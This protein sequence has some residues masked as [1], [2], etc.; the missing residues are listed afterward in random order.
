MEQDYI[1][2]NFMRRVLMFDLVYLL[3]LKQECFRSD[4]DELRFTITLILD[5]TRVIAE[6]EGIKASNDDL[7][8]QHAFSKIRGMIGVVVPSE[9]CIASFNLLLLDQ[10]KQKLG[11]LSC[12]D[13]MVGTPDMFR[14]VDKEIIIVAG[15]RNSQVDGLGAFEDP[16]A[17]QLLMTRARSFFWV[18][19]S[20]PQFSQHTQWREY[21]QSC[22]MLS[23]GR[24]TNY[25]SF[26]SH[27]DWMYPRLLHLIRTFVKRD[28]S[29]SPQGRH[30]ADDHR[31]DRSPARLGDRR[32]PRGRKPA[33][34]QRGLT[35]QDQ[36]SLLV[37]QG[38]SAGQKRSYSRTLEREKEEREQLRNKRKPTERDWDEVGAFPGGFSECNEEAKST[39]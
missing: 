15:V 24:Y 14:G 29:P 33:H 28:R 21:M 31:G 6:K 39:W 34:M 4:F 25:L 2:K 22:R 17:I 32:S 19:G 12:D 1:L 23:V 3:E 26:E 37:S 20:S 11:L 36:L 27:R 9:R 8:I 38:G 10:W 18:V 7:K 30:P 35:Y 5:L 16:S 13:I